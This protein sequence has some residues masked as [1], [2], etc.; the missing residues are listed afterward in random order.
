M[1]PRRKVALMAAG[2]ACCLAFSPLEGNAV[3]LR[4][5]APSE[6]ETAYLSQLAARPQQ[7]GMRAL[8]HLAYVR[9]Q[10]LRMVGAACAQAGH[11]IGGVATVPSGV[12]TLLQTRNRSLLKVALTLFRNDAGTLGL[13][14]ALD[15]L[16]D[17]ADD[18]AAIGERTVLMLQEDGVA[19]RPADFE[20]A[21]EHLDDLLLLA[22]QFSGLGLPTVSEGIETL[23]SGAIVFEREL[24]ALE[25][26]VADCLT[27]QIKAKA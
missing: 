11:A 26:Q 16:S 7:D 18:G 13:D 15:R 14:W 20:A 9:V 5:H 1:T 10:T 19:P 17:V 12:E 24:V 8:G 21:A 4:D 22:H 23:V 3:G 27:R 2:V 6:A 25:E